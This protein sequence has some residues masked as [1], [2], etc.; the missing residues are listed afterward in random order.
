M[1]SKTAIAALAATLALCLPVKADM[2][3]VV[4][5]GTV[6][7]GTDFSG[8]FGGGSLTGQEFSATFV[9]DTTRPGSGQTD[10][11]VFGGPASIPSA[12]VSPFLSASLTIANHT[13][14]ALIDRYGEARSGVLSYSV[15]GSGNNV[16]SINAFG[17]DAPGFVPFGIDVGPGSAQN[18]LWSFGD[19]GGNSTASSGSLSASHVTLT[20]GALVPVPGPIVGAG[21][22]G[23]LL[24][25]LGML[26]MLGW[27]RRQKPVATA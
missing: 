10:S 4:A 26:G 14:D 23:L 15:Q 12:Q 13:V 25:A 19:Q 21:L 3:T 16:L 18:S 11:G 17:T 5:T 20:L 24:A 27:R 7:N 6:T 2:L 8:L 1:T 22:P 9:F